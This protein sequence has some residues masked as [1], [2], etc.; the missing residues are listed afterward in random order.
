MEETIQVMDE[1]VELKDIK[2]SVLAEKTGISEKKV[3]KKM[4]T[5]MIFARKK[6]C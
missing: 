6:M 5:W 2:S 3:M 4:E 1:E